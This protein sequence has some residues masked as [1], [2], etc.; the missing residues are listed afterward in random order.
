MIEASLNIYGISYVSSVLQGTEV[1]DESEGTWES[2][3]QAQEGR[4]ATPKPPEPT[5][6]M[7]GADL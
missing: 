5:G 4:R 6:G 3:L 7:G 1:P 2:L